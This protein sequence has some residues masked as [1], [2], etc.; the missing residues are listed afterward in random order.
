MLARMVRYR[1]ENDIRQ[2]LAYAREHARVRGFAD[3][4][5]R[6]RLTF[7]LETNASIT[8]SFKIFEICFNLGAGEVYFFVVP[9]GDVL[10]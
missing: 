3:E 9:S 7:L 6:C 4:S 10:E 5:L 2:N 1:K 8:K